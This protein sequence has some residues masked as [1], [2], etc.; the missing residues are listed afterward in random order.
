MLLPVDPS[1]TRYFPLVSGV[2]MRLQVPTNWA[3]KLKASDKAVHVRMAPPAGEQ[4]FVLQIT[5]F[6]VLRD[7]FNLKDAAT[8]GRNGAQSPETTVGPLLPIEGKEGFAFWF[9]AVDR[10]A[11]QEPG[12]VRNQYKH[13]TQMFA[14]ARPFVLSAT[15]L[16]KRQDDSAKDALLQMARSFEVFRLDPSERRDTAER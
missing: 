6:P 10:P 15:L 16:A 7:N 8:A 1:S 12:A 2:T 14:Y 9:D 5:L 3:H 4:Q 11:E 13:L